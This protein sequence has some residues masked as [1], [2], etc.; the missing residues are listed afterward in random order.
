MAQKVGKCT[1]S[2]VVC[3]NAAKAAFLAQ[4]QHT[5]KYELDAFPLMWPQP[6][7]ELRIHIDDTSVGA[8][9]RLPQHQWLAGW[10]AAILQQQTNLPIS[11]RMHCSQT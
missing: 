7:C 3:K 1:E 4:A 10:R 5:I 6:P 11:G 8:L 2:H 9:W